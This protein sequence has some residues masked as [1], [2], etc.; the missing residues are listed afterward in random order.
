MYA[1]KGYAEFKDGLAEI[2]IEK[3]KPI[4]EKMKALSDEEVLEILRKG[5][6]KVR[7]I[8]KAKL[9]EVKEKVGF[10]L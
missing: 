7:P 9:D 3:L 2:I 10:I 4:Q 5:A 8:A 6:E 1:G